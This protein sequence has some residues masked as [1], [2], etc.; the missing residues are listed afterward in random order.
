MSVNYGLDRSITDS[1]DQHVDRVKRLVESADADANAAGS[2]RQSLTYLQENC[3]EKF[4]ELMQD[5]AV[6][7]IHRNY[8]QQESRPSQRNPASRSTQRRQ[9]REQ[10]NQQRNNRSEGNT[11]SESEQGTQLI[12]T[13]GTNALP[14]WVAWHHLKDKND[15][16]GN[17]L[18]PEPIQVRLI[19][20]AQTI[21]QMNVLK[22]LCE[23]DGAMVA[24][25]PTSPGDPETVRK[26]I[27][28]YIFGGKSN[29]N[30]RLHIHYTGGTQV[31]G[32]ETVSAIENKVGDKLK[33]SY[34]NARDDSG[35][36]MLVSRD[37]VLVD[38]TRVG[39][40]PCLKHIAKLNDIKI[41]PDESYIDRNG[42]VINLKAPV[43]TVESKLIQR[44]LEIVQNWDQEIQERNPHN[45]AEYKFMTNTF[46]NGR[47]MFPKS[48]DP[49]EYTAYG[50]LES[51]LKEFSRQ[52]FK[53]YNNVICVRG[54]AKDDFELDVVVVLGYQIVV[55]SCGT[56]NKTDTVKLKAM[57]AYHRAKQLGGDEARTVMLCGLNEKDAVE[58]EENLQD[59]I[60]T[61]FSPLQVWGKN[62]W[63][64]P[65]RP[66][67]LV[68]AFKDYLEEL[69]WQ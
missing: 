58:L 60:G 38:D 28:R 6:A 15:A 62:R 56:S 59:A 27:Q 24:T 33:T 47:K 30:K 50:A 14:I 45:T 19:H 69:G 34:L 65:R 51:T 53:L 16:V 66:D 68:N 2:V 36:P 37:G 23:S 29:G 43:S 9:P 64:M 21:S 4:Q 46:P 5:S 32:V 22:K 52:N 10:R 11:L 44:S 57:E 42:A 3:P 48:G 54:N 67:E 41:G 8:N 31:M 35:T 39:I 55:V 7:S 17:C 26:N 20:T 13:V 18:L 49:L 63:P 40:D 61:E 12:L 1:I 25:H